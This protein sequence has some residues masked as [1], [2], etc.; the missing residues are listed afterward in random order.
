MGGKYVCLKHFESISKPFSGFS[1]S[2]LIASV[3]YSMR[4]VDDESLRT[5]EEYLIRTYN[6]PSDR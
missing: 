4:N 1:S 2:S 6:S 5:V 3:L